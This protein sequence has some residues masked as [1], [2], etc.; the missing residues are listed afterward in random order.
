MAEPMLRALISQI[1]FFCLSLFARHVL[2]NRITCWKMAG[3]RSIR[4]AL[5]STTWGRV[6]GVQINSLLLRST[7]G[8]FLI[9]ERSF[10]L[11]FIVQFGAAQVSF[12]PSFD[13]S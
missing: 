9:R 11:Q 5:R 13:P 12:E 2:S 8:F 1:H 4:V 6:L 7:F 10:P 3:P